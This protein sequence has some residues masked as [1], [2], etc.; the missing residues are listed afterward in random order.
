[1]VRETFGPKREEAAEGR[2]KLSDVE[3]WEFKNNIFRQTSLRYPN[4]EGGQGRNMWLTK[5]EKCAKNFV[6]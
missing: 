3:W 6:L 5:Q 4:Q 2:I 1:V